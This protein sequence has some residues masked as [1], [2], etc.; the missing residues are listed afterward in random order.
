MWIWILTIEAYHH[1]KFLPLYFQLNIKIGDI[2]LTNPAGYDITDVFQKKYI[3]HLKPSDTLNVAVNPS[4]VFFGLAKLGK[5]SDNGD[6]Y[7]NEDDVL[8][9]KPI[10]MN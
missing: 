1:G 10:I 2:G 7:K 3:G 9:F 5:Y 8:R 6:Q 4:G